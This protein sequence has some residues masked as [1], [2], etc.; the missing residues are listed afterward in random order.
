MQSFTFLLLF[1]NN[2]AKKSAHK[3]LHISTPFLLNAM[4]I[5]ILALRHWVMKKE[6]NEWKSSSSVYSNSECSTILWLQICCN[7]SNTL[8]KDNVWKAKRSEQKKSIRWMRIQMQRNLIILKLYQ[9]YAQ[10]IGNK[11]RKSG[12]FGIWRQFTT[13]TRDKDKDKKNYYL[14]QMK[15]YET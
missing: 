11:N 4:N 9:K 2:R 6:K 10:R 3:Y 8:N 14:F 7:I 12:S 15:M 13:N 5:F 1:V